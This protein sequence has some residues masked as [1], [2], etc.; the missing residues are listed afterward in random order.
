[1]AET[2]TSNRSNAN[3]INYQ[4]GV[5]LEIDSK[6]HIALVKV[7]QQQMRIR[8]DTLRG[9]SAPPLAGETWLLDQPYGLGMQFAVPMNW[10]ADSDWILPTLSGAWSDVGS[11]NLPTGYRKEIEGWVT[12]CG[13]L[14]G[15]AAN[16]TAFVLPKGYRPGGTWSP[17]GVVILVTG[18]VKPTTTTPSLDGVRFM[19]QG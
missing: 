12:L 3:Q 6:N 7:G 5:V 17:S 16:S 11:P 10:S 9:K 14:T 8:T 15:G 4:I 2:K 18:E 13:K 1:M 19:A